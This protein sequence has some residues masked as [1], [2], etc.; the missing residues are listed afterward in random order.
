MEYGTVSEKEPKSRR[1]DK[2]LD[3]IVEVA[4]ELFIEK[5]YEGTSLNAILERVG[6]SKRNFYTKF[7]GKEG[8]FK[9]LVERNIEYLYREQLEEG[10]KERD[11]R[12]VLFSVAKRQIK[13]FEDPLLLGLYRIAV[14]DGIQFPEIAKAFFTA[15][16]ERAVEY[17][18]DALEKAAEKGELA[19]C[20]VGLAAYHFVSML[21]G[22]MFYELFFD[23]RIRPSKPE[24][25]AFIQSVV[26]LFLNGVLKKK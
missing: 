10:K 12:G 14:R 8:L 19:P 18:A 15:G 22:R 17:V 5:G 21:H 25:E 20:D 4:T 3:S 23:V 9:A 2:R 13:A 26:D 7:G 6:G 24:I 1:I 11:L 16:P